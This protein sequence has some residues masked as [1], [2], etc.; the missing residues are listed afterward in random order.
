VVVAV[1]VAVAAAVSVRTDSPTFAAARALL[2]LAERRPVR[3]RRAPIML[4]LHRRRLRIM[5]TFSVKA[6]TRVIA[7]TGGNKYSKRKKG[8]LLYVNLSFKANKKTST[9]ILIYFGKKI[10]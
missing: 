2:D 7:A 9:T 5:P 3:R 1:V 8:S 4:R 6:E 10:D